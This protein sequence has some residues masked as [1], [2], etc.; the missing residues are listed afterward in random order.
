[1]ASAMWFT[2]GTFYAWRNVNDSFK[3]LEPAYE[4][5]FVAI[6]RLRDLEASCPA[7]AVDA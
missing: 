1:M 7:M 4:D 5:D 2:I 3:K 6:Y